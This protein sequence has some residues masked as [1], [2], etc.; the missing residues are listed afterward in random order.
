MLPGCYKVRN[1]STIYSWLILPLLTISTLRPILMHLIKLN[2]GLILSS[3]AIV[4]NDYLSSI[5][6]LNNTANYIIELFESY[7]TLKVPRIT[8]VLPLISDLD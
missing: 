1:F 3:I 4:W 6:I 5:T 2:F 8:N 7:T